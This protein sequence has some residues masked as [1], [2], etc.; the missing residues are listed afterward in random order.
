M[1][2]MEARALRR[3]V[4]VVVLGGSV[5]ASLAIAS[6][7]L[8]VWE[9][10]QLG[11]LDATQAANASL[12]QAFV[13]ENRADLTPILSEGAGMPSAKVIE[14]LDSQV[15]VFSAGTDILKVKIF[16]RRGTI[17]FS[18]HAEETGVSNANNAYFLAAIEGRPQS[19][20]TYRGRF[21]AFDGHV[22]DRDLISSYIPVRIEGKTV[23]VVEV[24]ADR[25]PAI[26]GA[27]QA[28]R[29]VSAIV[30]PV[31]ALVFLTGI[32]LLVRDIRQRSRREEELARL[33]EHAKSA[34]EAKSRFLAYMSHELRT[35]LNAILGYAQL[36]QMEG[37]PARSVLSSGPARPR[38]VERIASAGWHLASMIDDLLDLGK[39]ESGV[40][41]V[42]RIPVKVGPILEECREQ[43]TAAAV[44][45][46]VRI[47][48]PRFEEGAGW[49]LGDPRRFR[50]VVLN[51]LGNAVKYNVPGG[52]VSVQV[53]QGGSSRVRIVVSDTGLG[54]P[55]S[56]VPKLFQ[57]FS[58]L[59]KGRTD[60]EGSG[61]GLA[62]SRRLVDLMGGSI[63][64]ESREGLG[65]QFS[66]EFVA[67]EAPR[68]PGLPG[69]VGPDAGR[70]RAG[71][72]PRRILY[73]EDTAA[74]FE[75]VRA[76][77]GRHAGIE[78]L[79][80]ADGETGVATALRERPE[81]ILLDMNLPDMHGLEVKERLDRDA[82]TA[83]IPVFA[84]SADAFDDRI[85]SALAAGFRGYLTKPLRLP[86]LLTAIEDLA[87]VKLNEDSYKS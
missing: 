4:S 21:D 75:L 67:A 68:E 30:V 73:V 57:P 19:Q 80:A 10:F 15:R 25:T 65:T 87:I 6:C 23:G 24:Y 86:D 29:E 48:V 42:V 51:L 54:I 70:R 53:V 38:H 3:K 41:D 7:L 5:L 85:S 82:R 8:T 45:N 79:R 50:Q 34:S 9:K 49:I 18:S 43:L 22:F 11:V 77:L 78:V 61:I 40:I 16:D 28:M 56:E 72:R 52:V 84:L 14:R 64:V 76:Y 83:G 63:R 62:L 60:I 55:A 20:L 32:A 27:R 37:D 74:S 31:L 47:E 17:I 44:E 69:D 66:V 26:A 71:H 46:S 81:V 36:L 35:P 1:P 13:N 59:H 2:E 39:I 33:V 12:T 58:R